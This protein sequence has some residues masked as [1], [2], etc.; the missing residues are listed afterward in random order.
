MKQCPLAQARSAFGV[1]P[2]GEFQPGKAGEAHFGA[3][4]Q[5]SEVFDFLHAPPV[6][7]ITNS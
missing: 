3:Q 6:E 4:S 7:G 2:D 5:Q 1:R